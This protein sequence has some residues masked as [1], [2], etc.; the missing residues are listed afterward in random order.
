MARF[1]VGKLDDIEVGAQLVVEATRDDV[2]VVR[3]E[4]GL[5]AVSNICSHEEFPLCGGDVEYGQIK[6]PK[7]GSWFELST[8]KALNLPA[9]RPIASYP[10]VVE[11]GIVFVEAP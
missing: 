11:D 6:C 8:G 4:D 3:T 5:F 2:L 1:L 7:H 9:V 10:V